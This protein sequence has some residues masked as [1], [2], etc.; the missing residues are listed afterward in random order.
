MAPWKQKGKKTDFI[1]RAVEIY[2]D[3]YDYSLSEFGKTNMNYVM[4]LCRRHDPPLKFKQKP[5]DHHS[6]QGCLVFGIAIR[7]QNK[8][9]KST[10]DFIAQAVVIHGDQCDYSLSEYGRRIDEKVVI[11]CTRHDLPA[12]FER[13]PKSHLFGHGCPLCFIS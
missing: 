4:I 5:N 11:L 10:A 2:G 3:L 1:A 13:R 9:R 8:L 7:V 12:Q 6:G